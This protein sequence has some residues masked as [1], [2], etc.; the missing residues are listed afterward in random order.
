[1]YLSCAT[2]KFQSQC[3]RGHTVYPGTMDQSR[4]GGITAGHLDGPPCRSPMS[5]PTKQGGVDRQ[6]RQQGPRKVYLKHFKL[7][8][9]RRACAYILIFLTPS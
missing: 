7:P 2:S 3:V 5:N 6:Q 8:Q 9:Q 4:K 1:M